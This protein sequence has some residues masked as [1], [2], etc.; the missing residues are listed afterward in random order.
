VP[1]N[2]QS[3]IAQAIALTGVPGS[4]AGPL[5]TIAM[6]ESGGNPNAVNNWDVNAKNGDPSRGI[7]QTIGA[8]FAAYA[9]PGHNTNI[10]D[11]VSNIAAAVEYIVSRYGTVFNVPGIRS[12]AAGGSYQGYAN[13]GLINE[14]I[15]GTGLRSGRGYTFGERGSE[16]I[17]PA[18][19]SLAS[20]G[21]GSYASNKDI[22]D[23]LDRIATLLEKGMTLDGQRVSRAI[24]P[25]LTNTIRYGTASKF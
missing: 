10:F 3:W 19:A 14:P 8:T 18:G 12:L 5:A 23:R 16:W 6:N 7:M 20:G 2:V 1:G 17:V 21:S 11:P 9:L 13:G 15:I 25:A 22:L 24:L 4:W